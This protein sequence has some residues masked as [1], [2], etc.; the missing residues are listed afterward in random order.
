MVQFG[1][2]VWFRPLQA[3]MAD[4]G[5]RDPKVMEGRYVGTHGRNCDVL[6]MTEEGV[7]KGNTVHR[8]PPGERWSKEGL[9]KLVGVPWKLR[10]RRDGEET[11][12]SKIKLVLPEAPGRLTPVGRDG[13]PR[14]LYVRRKDLKKED[15][16]DDYTPGCLGCDAI[17]VRLP[18]ITHSDACRTR[19]QEKLARSEEGRKRLEDAKRRKTEAKEPDVGSEQGTKKSRI[20]LSTRPDPEDHEVQAPVALGAPEKRKAESELGE[21]DPKTPKASPKKGEKRS[22]SETLDE[23]YGDAEVADVINMPAIEPPVLPPTQVGGGSGSAAQGADISHQALEP[24]SSTT[25]TAATIR[26]WR[27]VGKC[28]HSFTDF[29]TAELRVLRTRCIRNCT[30]I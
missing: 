17:I 25:S 4:K 8:I 19:I 1:E 14:N 22:P 3:Y 30:G 13:G 5:D 24:S 27:S 11:V 16:S 9:D 29:S 21:P 12:D 18:A 6:C 7:R 20:Q 15:G 28:R 23:L 10:P 2:R 26:K